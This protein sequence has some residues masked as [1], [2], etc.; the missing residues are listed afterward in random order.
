MVDDGIADANAMITQNDRKQLPMAPAP[1]F[2]LFGR[3]FFVSPAICI[4][5][6][7]GP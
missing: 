1:A 3:D 2:S 4:L 6:G 7:L 5:G